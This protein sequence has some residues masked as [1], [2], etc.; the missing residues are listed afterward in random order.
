MNNR[1]Y[2]LLEKFTYVGEFMIST[3]SGNNL[4]EFYDIN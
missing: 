3:M 4:I 2:E 1:N